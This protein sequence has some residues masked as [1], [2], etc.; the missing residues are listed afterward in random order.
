MKDKVFLLDLDGTMYAGTEIIPAAKRLIDRL[1]AA[2]RTYYFLTNNAM[3]T[4]GENARHMLD[5]GFEHIRPEQFFNS[6]MAAAMYA[7]S[8]HLGKTAW[9]IGQ[10][11]LRQ[12]LEHQGFEITED[13]PDFLFVGLDRQADY[14]EYS[15]GLRCLLDGAKLIGTNMDRILAAPDGFDI[16]NGSIVKMFEYASGQKSPAIGKP[17]ALMLDLCLQHFGLKKDQIVL[18]GDNLE[19]DIA[20]GYN[21]H[22]ESIFVESGVHTRKDLERFDVHPDAVIQSLDEIVPESNLW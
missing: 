17:S 5:M 12:A 8:L 19:T 16:G 10:E 3:R 4:P 1:H 9:M 20:L 7:G 6:A 13:H 22:V 2:H 18:V 14:R 15:R 21:S 11:G